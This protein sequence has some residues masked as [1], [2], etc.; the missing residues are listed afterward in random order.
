MSAPLAEA[1]ARE[2]ARLELALRD[3]ARGRSFTA[4]EAGE[5]NGRRRA[6]KGDLILAYRKLVEEL[7]PSEDRGDL[8]RYEARIEELKSDDLFAP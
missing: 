7:P 6:I 4:G 5:R 1:W 3:H 8:A 2:V